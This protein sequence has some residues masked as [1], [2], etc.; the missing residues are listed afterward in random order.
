MRQKVWFL[1]TPVFLL[2]CAGLFGIF[3][4]TAKEHAVRTLTEEQS[5]HASQAARGIEEFFAGWTGVLGSLARM[6]AV[7]EAGADGR[8]YMAFFLESHG[9]QIRAITRVNAEGRIL[10]TV[11]PSPQAVGSD[12]SRQKHVREILRDHR[13]VVSDVFRAVQGYDAVALHVPVFKG[14]RFD[15]TLAVVVNFQNLAQRYL[16]AIAIGKTGRAWVVSRDGTT[17]FDPE[18]GR[19][20]KSVF[21]NHRAEPSVLR[22]AERMVRG[23]RGATTYSVSP[24]SGGTG[25]R[26]Y[27]VY[28]PIRLGTNFWSIVVSSSEAEVLSS[29]VA[30]RNRLAAIA[31]LL[32]AGGTFFAYLGVKAWLIVREEEKRRRVEESLRASEERFR[33]IIERAKE[34]ILV[35]DA[36]TGELRYANPEACR[37]FG[38]DREALLAMDVP[39]LHPPDVRPAAETAFAS[40]VRGAQ[41]DAQ[42]ACLRKDGTTFQATI[43]GTP[44]SFDGRD[45]VAGF[46]SDVSDRLQLE[47]ERV[48]SAKFEAIGVLAGGIAH[49]FNNLLQAMFGAISLAKRTLDRAAPA[50]ALLEQAES[51]FRQSVGLTTQLLTFS[52]GGAPQKR[53]LALIPLIDAVAK[54]SLSGSRAGCRL[55]IAADLKAVE[56]DEGQIAQVIQNL[57]L[58]ADQ[59]MPRGGTIVIS[60]RN[61]RA[62][63]P[64]LPAQLE[65]G[66]YAE[67]SVQDSGV[68]M[69]PEEVA[70]IFD[71]YYT[72]KA[73]GTGLGLATSYAIVKKHGGIITVQTET[74]KGSLFSFYLPATDAPVPDRGAAPAP[75]HARRARVLLLDDEEMVR[76]V[77]AAM[78]RALGHDVETATHGQEAIEKYRAARDA[79]RPFDLALLDLTIRG[80]LGGADT[81]AALQAFDPD[82]KAIVSSGYVDSAAMAEF[83]QLGF[84]DCLR[85]PYQLQALQA[86]LDA[87]LA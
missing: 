13:P 19:I 70:R 62:P 22:M 60:A 14:G 25:V 86:A 16:A 41:V 38:Y 10:H 37:L 51:S 61:V 29:L 64:E 48:K 58:N 78:L 6:D 7:V 77:T 80:G 2:A 83:R 71:P 49:D 33:A 5:L 45:C 31:G 40:M 30:L 82:V 39:R 74:G 35:A 18:P 87:V 75:T 4:S 44:L 9:D 68:G 55:E 85:K 36:R 65:P 28:Q 26:H 34:G 81:L 47:E 54:F 8:K 66:D 24:P 63:G 56:A 59:A 15:G 67:V 1:S 27:A 17:L 43:R 11:P 73:K 69:R 76:T 21:E 50:F 20:G 53:P 72:T 46:F 23:E 3:Y 57:V 42:L 12:I 32:L 84:R 52:R 79:G